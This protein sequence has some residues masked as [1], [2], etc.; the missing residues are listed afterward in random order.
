M[1][2]LLLLLEIKSH[3]RGRVGGPSKQANRLEEEK[4]K[5]VLF[6]SISV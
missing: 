4:E 1:L 2:L 6:L 3:L 5:A